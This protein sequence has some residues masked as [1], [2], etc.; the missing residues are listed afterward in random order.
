MTSGLIDGHLTPIKQRS[1]FKGSPAIRSRA[2]AAVMSSPPTVT[3]G[4]AATALSG[5]I[6]V[7]LPTELRVSN[8]AIM[9]DSGRYAAV[10]P[11]GY[12][13]DIA[14]SPRSKGIQV[15]VY[16]FDSPGRYWE[17]V[18]GTLGVRYWLFVNDQPATL[19]PVAIG[20]A[21]GLQHILVD[22]GAV[23]AV[24]SPNRITIMFDAGSFSSIFYLKHKQSEVITY[25]TTRATGQLIWLGDS[26]PEGNWA[27]TNFAIASEN[28]QYPQGSFVF[29]LGWLLG[30]WD[31][32]Q[33]ICMGGRG[34]CMTNATTGNLPYQGN[35]TYD[36]PLLVRQPSGEGTCLVLQS[37]TNDKGGGYTTGQ[38]QTAFETAIAAAIA[39]YPQITILGVGALGCPPDSGMDVYDA[40][41][42]A[43]LTTYGRGDSFISTAGLFTG[44][45]NEGAAGGNGNSDIMA[46]PDQHL[47]YNGKGPPHP[48]AL[49]HAH[50]ARFLAPP[51]AARLGINLTSDS[52]WTVT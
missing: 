16:E 47:T 25:P 45:G 43:A 20:S 4:G 46:P 30:L 36:L 33:G 37:S 8:S 12:A 9:L 28:V 29:Q 41:L 34:V 15:V 48:N 24:G 7:R 49:G 38:V 40:A 1:A 42:L 14:L 35:I 22:H 44:T 32:S 21:A 31:V 5:S 19:Q 50:I 52:A 13:G 26:I 23:P 27:N 2:F 6:A 11:Y 10:K 18:T 17:F 3:T 51:V 39:A